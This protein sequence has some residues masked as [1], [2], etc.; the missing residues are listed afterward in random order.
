MIDKLT[1]ADMQGT[2]TPRGQPAQALPLS[3]AELALKRKLNEVI[4][5]VNRL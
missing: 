2:K 3:K 1:N 4:D 5:E